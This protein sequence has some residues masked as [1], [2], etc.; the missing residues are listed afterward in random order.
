[1]WAQLTQ[2]IK[3]GGPLYSDV[4]LLLVVLL[5][6][7]FYAMYFGRNRIVSFILAFYPA[8]FL[9]SIFPFSEKLTILHGDIPLLF[10]KIGIFLIFF[11]PLNIIINRYIFAESDYSGNSHMFRTFGLALASLILL[12]L[13][14]YT[15]INLNILH[16]F[17]ETIDVLFVGTVRIFWWNVAPLAIMAFL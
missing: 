12:V 4:A 3:S 13:F 15:I 9:Y 5:I 10:N 11:L 1:M 17:S 14:S 7:F 6:L 8:S 2:F 16:N